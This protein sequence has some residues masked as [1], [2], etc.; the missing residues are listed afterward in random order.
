MNKSNADH[1]P[2]TPGRELASSNGLM[3]LLCPLLRSRRG[4]NDATTSL[5]SIA[6]MGESLRS[7][8]VA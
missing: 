1:A 4:T 5:P 8:P 7:L 3:N 2:A 6:K